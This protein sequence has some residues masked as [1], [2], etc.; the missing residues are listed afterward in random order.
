MAH[1]LTLKDNW[2]HVEYFDV[3]DSF[4][5]IEQ[6]AQPQFRDGL[7]RF[8]R[9]IFDYSD[10]TEINFDD[11][12]MKQFATLGRILGGMHDK[13]I[14]AIVLMS[15]ERLENAEKYKEASTTPSWDVTVCF[16]LDEAEQ[17]MRR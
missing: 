14:V 1:R 6:L 11:E 17:V 12:D 15:P 16:N 3:V 2:I 4:D 7:A 9:V 5:V 8:Q 10:A 13:V